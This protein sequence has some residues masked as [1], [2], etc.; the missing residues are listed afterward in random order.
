MSHG[1]ER[2]TLNPRMYS[3]AICGVSLLLTSMKPGIDAHA[4]DNHHIV[5]PPVLGRLHRPGRAAARVAR[6]E[7]RHERRAP[8]RNLIAVVKHPVDRMR[9]AAGAH[10]LERR[11]VFLHGHDLGAGQLLDQRIAFHVI[12]VGVAAEDDL[13]VGGLEAELLHRGENQR[14]VGFVRAVDED[15]SLRRRD[16]ERRQALGADV[17]DI[18]SDLVRR[19][20]RAL[21][22]WRADVALEQ[23]LE[24][25]TCAALARAGGL[26][27]R[28][29]GRDRH[30]TRRMR[31]DRHTRDISVRMR[32]SGTDYKRQYIICRA[33]ESV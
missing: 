3:S 18:V 16:Q 29:G 6:R 31:L 30:T 5:G 21:L 2:S 4:A 25:S 28:R 7:V 11:N 20:S 24:S 8:K 12:G 17:P 19:K 10:A 33:S 22:F 23:L 1:S 26:L 32:A 9:L 14:H 27:C 15:V 13:D